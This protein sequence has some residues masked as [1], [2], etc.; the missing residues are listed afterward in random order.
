MLC[1]GCRKAAAGGSLCTDCSQPVPTEE[2]FEGQGGHYLKVL[3]VL[4]VALFTAAMVISS[5]RSGRRIG[6]ESLVQLR[7]FWFYMALFFL[8]T[9]IGV[10][11]WFML[12]DEAIIIT[13]EYIERQSR[14]GDERFLWHELDAFNKQLLPFRETR[15]GRIASLSRWLSNRRLFS[16]IPPYT[17]ELVGRDAK[18]SARSFRLEPG[19][20]DDMPWLLEIIQA[21]A[22]PPNEV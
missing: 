1:P 6:L 20:V 7:W 19:S 14:W 11:F 21:K 22:G 13:D 10:Y 9:G 17:Y 18:G 16:G 2:R 5:L 12:R 4:S 15:L 8:P 3:F